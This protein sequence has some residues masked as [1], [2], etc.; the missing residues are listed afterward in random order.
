MEYFIII[1]L[2]I[3]LIRKRIGIKFISSRWRLEDTGRYPGKAIAMP[4]YNRSDD[5]LGKDLKTLSE[6]F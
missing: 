1:L 4:N 5:P 3:Q 2:I 6:M